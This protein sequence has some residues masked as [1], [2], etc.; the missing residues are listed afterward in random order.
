[1]GRGMAAK[2]VPAGTKMRGKDGKTW[3][4]KHGKS[5]CRWSKVTKIG[6]KKK[7]T[8]RK[9]HKATKT[10]S[11]QLTGGDHNIGSTRAL[12]AKEI[13]KPDFV[14]IMGS[15]PLTNGKYHWTDH[16]I[17]ERAHAMYMLLPPKYRTARVSKL[18]SRGAWLWEN[19]HERSAQELLALRRYVNDV[20][21]TDIFKLNRFK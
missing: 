3:I 18:N 9:L 14:K 13:L 12:Y 5:S 17:A 7:P 4:S 1:M 6:V 21:S 19:V 10:Q 11:M 2:H 8:K 20:N 15:P 16:S